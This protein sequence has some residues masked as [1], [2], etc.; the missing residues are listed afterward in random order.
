[1]AA[2]DLKQSYDYNKELVGVWRREGYHQFQHRVADDMQDKISSVVVPPLKDAFRM[3]EP[4]ATGRTASRIFWTAAEILAFKRLAALGEAGGAGAGA[5]R[6]G[7]AEGAAAGGAEKAAE[8]ATEG[9]LRVNP[10]TLRFSQTTAGG[11]GGAEMLRES[12][13][14]KGWEGPPVDVVR[15]SEGLTTLDNTRVAVAQEQGMSSIPVRVH[16][17]TESLP[18]SMLGRPWDSAGNTAKTWG[19]A[20]KLRTQGQRP[21]LSPTGTPEAPRMPPPKPPPEKNG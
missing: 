13:K 17:A 15:T 3:P 10:K 5:G 9:V 16:E 19:E 18:E 12:M 11:G 20:L 6:A 2:V 7:T 14:A 8:A 1:M 4:E 21:L